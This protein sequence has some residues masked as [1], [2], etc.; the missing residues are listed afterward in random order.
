MRTVLTLLALLAIAA[1]PVQAA[2]RA[3]PST[4]AQKE[5]EQR[6]R[7]SMDMGLRAQRKQQRM[8]AD[9]LE[10][11]LKAQQ[12]EARIKAK[13]QQIDQADAQKAEPEP[14][15]DADPY[16][17]SDLIRQLRDQPATPNK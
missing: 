12:V 13:T 17:D 11:Q 16:A 2:E 3:V 15:M 4:K 1:A 6:M 8:E 7:R 5:A 14:P 9:R 10:S